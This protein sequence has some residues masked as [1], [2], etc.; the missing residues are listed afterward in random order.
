VAVVR[1]LDVASSE[2]A[3]LSPGEKAGVLKATEML[4][5]AGDMLGYPHTSSARG[6]GGTLRELRPRQ[7]RSPARVLYRRI[8]GEFVIGAVTSSHED[9]RRYRTALAH[10]RNRL[11]EEQ[12]RMETQQDRRGQQGGLT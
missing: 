10:A 5:A 1:W 4:E 2:L 7:G 6:K 3:A 8:G 9:K 12:R 11:D